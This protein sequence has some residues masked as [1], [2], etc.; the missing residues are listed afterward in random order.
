MNINQL[1]FKRPLPDYWLAARRL[2]FQETELPHP[3]DS[4]TQYLSPVERATIDVAL[5]PLQDLL[6]VNSILGETLL[7]LVLF[8]RRGTLKY[9][10]GQYLAGVL[11]DVFH[12]AHPSRLAKRGWVL[13]AALDEADIGVQ[14]RLSGEPLDGG[15]SF[16]RMRMTDRLEEIAALPKESLRHLRHPR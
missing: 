13:M 11:H 1:N 3:R 7:R 8:E 6:I 4:L 9:M 12:G 10:S 16:R 15:T 14:I 2:P 5:D